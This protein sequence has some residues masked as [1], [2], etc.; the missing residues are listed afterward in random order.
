YVMMKHNG[1]LL[2]DVVGLGKTIIACMVIKKF[3]FENGMHTKVLVICPPAIQNNWLRTSKDFQIEKNIKVL[4]L[5]KLEEVINPEKLE[6]GNAEDF[7]VI[8]VD[9]SHKFRNDYT[10][11]YQQLQLI[12]KIPRKHADGN[13]D[14]RKKVIL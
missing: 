11:M 7:D 9:E 14:T 12:C 4:S 13:S 5:G 10:Q 8:V 3:I 6:V 1:F 2:A